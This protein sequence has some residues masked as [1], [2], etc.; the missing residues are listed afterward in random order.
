MNGLTMAAGNR[1]RYSIEHHDGVVLIIGSVPMSA[2]GTLTKLAP[3]PKRAVLDMTLARMAGASFAFGNPED[4]DAYRKKLEPGR[5][6]HFV[7]VAGRL[8]LP[9]GSAQWLGAGEHGRSS[10]A[11]FRH[12]T[13]YQFD[14]RDLPAD[15]AAAHPLDAD[16]FKRCL[17]LVQT[18]PTL[19]ESIHRLA[20]LSPVWGGI[21]R[22]WYDLEAAMNDG[23]PE[24]VSRYINTIR[25]TT[26]GA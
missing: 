8:G 12:L 3:D 13:G 26:P 23:K 16:D 25:A 4:C 19:R 15:A 10:M 18:V 6:A 17:L 2:F 14:E 1:T 7:A 24:D 20:E 11:M 22:A 5:V 21:A 9:D